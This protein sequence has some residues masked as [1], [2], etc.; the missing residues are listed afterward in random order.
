MIE[1][2]D[3]RKHF[4]RLNLLDQIDLRV[5]RGGKL[6]II[7]QKG[8]FYFDDN[9]EKLAQGQVKTIAHLK[10]NPDYATKVR[11]K[12]LALPTKARELEAGSSE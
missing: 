5:N 1:V 12:V 8:A 4:G 2:S 10:A 9:G 11:A 6:G 3:V 7:G